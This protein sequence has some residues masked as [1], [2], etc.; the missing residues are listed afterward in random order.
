MFPDVLCGGATLPWDLP[1]EA[2]TQ[3]GREKAPTSQ[4][5]GGGVLWDA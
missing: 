2:T 1:Q 5:G 3:A 4:I